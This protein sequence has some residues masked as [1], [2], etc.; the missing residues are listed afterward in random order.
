MTMRVPSWQNITLNVYGKDDLIKLNT[1]NWQPVG[2]TYTIPDHGL[3]KFDYDSLYKLALKSRDP[4]GKGKFI[5]TWLR[6]KLVNDTIRGEEPC[7]MIYGK[8]FMSVSKNEIA[9]V[10]VDTNDVWGS[11]SVYVSALEKWIPFMVLRHRTGIYRI[12]H[13]L[14]VLEQAEKFVGTEIYSWSMYDKIL[15]KGQVICKGLKFNLKTGE[16][17]NPNIDNEPK[18]C[19]EDKDKRKEWRKNITAFKKQ[20]RTRVRIGAVDTMIDKLLNVD[21]TSCLNTLETHSKLLGTYGNGD[22]GTTKYHV[23]TL[24]RDVK[25]MKETVPFRVHMNWD[26]AIPFIAKHVENNTMTNEIFIP[27]CLTLQAI[28]ESAWK[29]EM[30]LDKAVDVLFTKLSLPLRRHFG[31]IIKEATIPP[32]ENLSYAFMPR[33]RYQNIMLPIEQVH[34]IYRGEIK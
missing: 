4:R 30:N 5:N 6:L 14:K 20:L 28:K 25:E 26:N 32:S 18:R 31:V 15:K 16:L 1:D 33:N 22:Y 12:M 7:L 27:L 8:Q 9:T 13:K 29:S 2:N 21:T 19:V 34:N 24:R 17:L 23:E 10:H 3:G 11:P